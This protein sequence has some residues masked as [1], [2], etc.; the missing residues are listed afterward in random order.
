MGNGRLGAMVFGDTVKERIALNEESMWYGGHQD[1]NNPDAKENLPRVRQLIVD[2][3]IAEAERL[4]KL[5]FS[6]CPH[7][8]RVYQPLG[9]LIIEQE[10]LET[11]SD[12]RRELDFVDAVCRISYKTEDTEYEREYFTTAV[13]KLLVVRFRAKGE[14]KLNFSARLE[15]EVFFTGTGKA[16][17]RSIALWGQ[18]GDDGLDYY[19]QLS[20]QAK[21][22]RLYAIG[23]SVAEE[24]LLLLGAATNFNQQ[25][26]KQYVKEQIEN[27]FK[28]GY[29]T[30][31]ADH[32][33]EYQAYFSRMELRIG[34]DEQ[35]N[36]STDQLLALAKSGDIPSQLVENYFDFGRYLLISSSRP[37]TLP[38]NL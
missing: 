28:K 15:R 5:S 17:E 33:K 32:K 25:N 26:P 12:Y 1:R 16:D 36:L 27:G 20:G 14:K 7:E 9:D 30:L 11:V 38:A 29:E 31:L 22:G 37:K 35:R 8:M 24:V 34:G 3:K 4:L 10:N 2:G 6:G 13:E 18:L 19:M 21:G 23:Q